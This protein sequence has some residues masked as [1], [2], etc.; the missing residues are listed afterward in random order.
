[1]G[2]KVVDGCLWG[3]QTCQI[4]P[5]S[6]SDLGFHRQDVTKV[7]DTGKII[8]A[9]ATDKDIAKE[10]DEYGTQSDVRCIW[11]WRS[12]IIRS[13][14]DV[15]TCCTDLSGEIYLG[16]VLEET[17][18]SIWNGDRYFSLRESH[19]TGKDMPDIC[20]NCYDKRGY[21]EGFIRHSISEL[22]GKGMET[23]H[24]IFRNRR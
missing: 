6:F 13:N 21:N 15:T 20:H 2:Q 12:L 3:D 9:E 18:Q 16:S 22:R 19:I 10:L 5:E 17:I 23:K 1:M 4:N 14:G 11:P 24:N 8:L 7:I